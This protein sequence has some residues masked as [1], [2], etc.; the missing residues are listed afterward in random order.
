MIHAQGTLTEADTES[1]LG[2]M[3]ACLNSDTP[4]ILVSLTN[5]QYVLLESCT[6]LVMA[7]QMANRVGKGF[8][9]YNPTGLVAW[10]CTVLP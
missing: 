10:M 5:L 1:F 2:M 8:A 3:V 6:L 9:L 4:R 7:H